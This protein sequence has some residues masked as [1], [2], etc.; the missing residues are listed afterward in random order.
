MRKTIIFIALLISG[1]KL[2]AQTPYQTSV[3]LG[4]DL[5]SYG[6]MFGPQLKHVFGTNAALQAQLMFSDNSY[7]YVGADY[8]YTKN[9][10]NTKGV[11]WYLGVGPQMGFAT[12]GSYNEF[13]LRPQAGLEFKLPEVPLGIHFDWKPWWRLSHGTHFTPGK[14]TLGL[15]YIIK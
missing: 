8:Q 14:F 6:S 4:I 13:V 5:G 3:G 7:M 2:S 10:P 15:K 12:K 9:F 11:A 1:L